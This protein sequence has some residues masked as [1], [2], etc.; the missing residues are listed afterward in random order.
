MFDGERADA[1]EDNKRVEVVE[2][3]VIVVLHRIS[4]CPNQTVRL[5]QANLVAAWDPGRLVLLRRIE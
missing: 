4:K 2:N 1:V 5:G 3:S